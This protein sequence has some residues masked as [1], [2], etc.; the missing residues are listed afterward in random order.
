MCRGFVKLAATQLVL[1]CAG[2]YLAF[3]LLCVDEEEDLDAEMVHG[4]TYQIR[5]H[6]SRRSI[7]MKHSSFLSQDPPHR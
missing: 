1:D 7:Q 5:H 6:V 2:P 4:R 3:V